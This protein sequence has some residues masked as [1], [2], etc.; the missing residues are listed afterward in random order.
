MKITP[1]IS[2]LVPCY[3]VEKYVAQ[4]LDSIL[5]QTLKDIEVICIND[6]S[7]DNTLSVFRS[8]E[9]IDERIKVL[10]KSNSGY[11][12]SMNRGL[13]LCLGKYIGI[14]ESDDF[15]EPNMFEV[16]FDTAEKFN[17][18]IARCC[19]FEFKNGTEVPV[20]NEWVPKNILIDPNVEKSVFSQAPAI[21]CSIYKNSWLKENHIKFLPT[22]GA[23]YQDTSFA[24]KAYA[25]ARRVMMLGTPMLHYRLDNQNSS[26][27]NPGKVYCVCDEWDE[28]YRF[29]RSNKKKFGHLF[30]IMPVLQYGTYKWNLDRLDSGLRTK[31]LAHWALE[32]LQ[33]LIKGELPLHKLDPN[34]RSKILSVLRQSLGFK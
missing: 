32:I 28:I 14:V 4:C 15:I 27:N 17:L 30:P 22:P 16:L 24:F 1:K 3:N 33:H 10:N 6:G 13:A 8:F 2:V 19:Y 21:W 11:G 9:K 7:T 31:F 5:S 12:D 25:C 26:I 20:Y 29:V 34:Y 18:E 23:S